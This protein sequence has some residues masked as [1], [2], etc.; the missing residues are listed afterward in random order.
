M[1]WLVQERTR[2]SADRQ[3]CVQ[4]LDDERPCSKIPVDLSAQ[5]RLKPERAVK[6]G[7]TYPALTVAR[8]TSARRSQPQALRLAR[9]C[10]TRG[11]TPPR[12]CPFRS[13]LLQLAGSCTEHRHRHPRRL[14]WTLHTVV[15]TLCTDCPALPVA[16]LKR[17][18]LRT[19]DQNLRGGAQM[20]C[21]RICS[22]TSFL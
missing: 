1:I 6:A 17:V 13:T 7:R 4:A 18:R 22:A 15:S 2:K 19:T 12:S 9:L 16:T 8:C 20:G 5:W 11:G 3:V 21:G 14:A 10:G